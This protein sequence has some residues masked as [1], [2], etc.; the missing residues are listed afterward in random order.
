MSRTLLRRQ[1]ENLGLLGV[2][3]ALVVAVL[4]TRGKVTTRERESRSH[5]LLA[6]WRD[7]EVTRVSYDR[8]DVHFRLERKETGDDYVGEWQLTEPYVEDAEPFSMEKL[9]GTLQHA[10]W[11]RRIKPEQVDRAAFGLD[12]PR[13]VIEVQMGDVVYRLRL[14]KDAASPKGA[15][16]LEIT[17]EGAPR[18]GVVI[19]P[20]T[21]LAELRLDAD[22]FRERYVMPY[23]SSSLKRFRLDGPGGERAFV[24]APWGG[25]RFDGMMGDVRAGRQALDRVLLQFARTIADDLVEVSAAKKALEGADT[26]TIRQT[27]K[28]PKLGPG[29]VR[30]GGRCPGD[31][32]RI[33][34]LRLQPDE[35]AGCVSRSVWP[36]LTTPREAIVDR[37]LFYMRRDEVETLEVTRGDEK[38]RLDRKEEGFVMRSPVEGAV[39]AE[40]GNARLD[41][42]IDA[43]GRPA[44]DVDLAEVGLEPPAGTVVLRS[45]A[46]SEK[47]VQVET[48]Q[49]GVPRDDGSVFARRDQDGVVLELS[50][51]AARALVPDA[52]LVRSRHVFDY[53]L[54][55]LRRVE[56]HGS[57]EQVFEREEKGLVRMSAP[58]GFGA[59]AALAV[60]AMDAL[61]T[62]TADRWAAD[63]DDGAFG[64]EDPVLTVR[65]STKAAGKEE[66]FHGLIVGRPTTSGYF[67]TVDG[68]PGVFVMPRRVFEVV[69][70]LVIDRGAFA[71]DPETVAA[72]HLTTADRRVTLERLGD[73]FLQTEGEQLSPAAI[74]RIV[75]ALAVL[76]PE[77]AV[78]VGPARPEHGLDQPL[79]K[80]EAEPANGQPS[81]SWKI[82]AGDSWRGMAIHYARAQGVD[83]VFAI[84]RGQVHQILDAL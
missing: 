28:D 7:D 63:A 84:P 10:S 18:K 71:V 34:A 76:R 55:E 36:G 56:I 33:V 6:A 4:V 21:L 38:L 37:T 30:I 49:I 12:E 69:T 50:R 73:Q 64:L 1:I 11:V 27:P 2:A 79:L 5:N 52:T 29:E 32:E 54:D 24:K 53:R 70:T 61:R 59:D 74:Q 14:G 82:G 9:L 17:G 75:D 80:L 20:E 23:L 44:E 60:E 16:Y 48:V 67:A 15:A 26:V 39:D 13:M 51:E 22:T 35:L 45:T 42:I 72:V 66:V 8:G 47:D 43:T 31:P 65:F 41:A 40:A 62:L 68:D 46:A 57:R 3:I 58:E 83:A 78:E 77:A 25:W 19:V 81:H